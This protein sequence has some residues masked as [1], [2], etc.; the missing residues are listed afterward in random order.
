MLLEDCYSPVGFRVPLFPSFIIDPSQASKGIPFV[1][2]DHEMYS[3][4]FLA[5]LIMGLMLSL[6]FTGWTKALEVYISDR[7]VS[8]LQ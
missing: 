6:S 2:L 7:L 5:I 1:S 8:F 3:A 4:V